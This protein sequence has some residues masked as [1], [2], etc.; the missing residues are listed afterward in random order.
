LEWRRDLDAIEGPSVE[1]LDILR[2]HLDN[3][4]V[5]RRRGDRGREGRREKSRGLMEEAR[6]TAAGERN[7]NDR[8]GVYN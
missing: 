3:R 1:E 8:E 2:R 6:L 5:R 4:H 7:P